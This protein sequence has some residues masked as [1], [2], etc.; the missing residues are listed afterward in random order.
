LHEAAASA[1]ASGA[2]NPSPMAPQVPALAQSESKARFFARLGL[3]LTNGTHRR[4]YN[5]MKVSLEALY[6]AIPCL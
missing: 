6:C 5:M 3:D 4:V 1:N 2:N